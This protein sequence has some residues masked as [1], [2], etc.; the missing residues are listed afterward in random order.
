MTHQLTKIFLCFLGCV[1]MTGVIAAQNKVL[2]YAEPNEHSK[3]VTEVDPTTPF[4][5]IYRTSDWVKVGNQKNGDT[6]WISLK[7]YREVVHPKPVIQSVVM[8]V[9][10]QPNKIEKTEIIAYK[11]GKKL[12]DKEAR[13]LWNEMKDRHSQM[14]KHWRRMHQE[15]NEWFQNSWEW[16]NRMFE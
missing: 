2:F 15:M 14:E 4:V 12:D 3:V 16:F 7:Q 6:G 5:T 13:K 9:T 10:D 11:D 8:T 1:L